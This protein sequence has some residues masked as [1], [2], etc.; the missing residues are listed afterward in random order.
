MGHRYAGTADCSYRTIV[1]KI[2]ENKRLSQKTKD[3]L[4]HDVD[5]LVGH[6]IADFDSHL[7]NQ[8][9]SYWA[10]G[11]RYLKTG[12]WFSDSRDMILEVMTKALGS[13]TWEHKR[14]KEAGFIERV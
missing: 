6:I 4:L 9:S 11:S 12:H 14:F 3:E 1:R 7:R 2:K 5:Y 10:C 8:Y 13:V